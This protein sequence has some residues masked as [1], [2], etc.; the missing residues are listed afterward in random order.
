M[1]A[2]T[3]PRDNRNSIL[4]FGFCDTSCGFGSHWQKVFLGRRVGNNPL[5]PQNFIT[6]EAKSQEEI[7]GQPAQILFLFFVQSAHGRLSARVL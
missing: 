4:H 1:V 5:R 7:C 3:S 2:C 6:S